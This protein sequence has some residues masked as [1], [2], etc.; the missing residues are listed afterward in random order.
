MWIEREDEPQ[1][2]GDIV[3]RGK[4]DPSVFDVVEG[5]GDSPWVLACDHGGRAIPQCLGD[6]GVPALEL[7]R[8]IA[9]DIGAAAV[10][11]LLADRLGAWAIVGN[12]SRLLIDLNRPLSSPQSI[13]L[14][15]EATDIPGNAGIP[16]AQAEARRREFFEP[17]HLRIAQE[18]DRRRDAGIATLLVAMHSFTPVYLGVVRPWHAGVLY[19]REQRLARLLLETMP[20]EIGLVVGDNQPY[21]VSDA[22]D[23]TVVTHG[24]NRGLV[25]VELEIRQ[26]LVAFQEGRQAWASRLARLLGNAR[27]RL[28]Y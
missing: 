6:L 24:E 1:G 20:A 5:R 12:Y 10:T 21:A 15:S 18:L 13:I 17:Y 19:N 14:H 3:L 7:E 27:E 4:G 16:K 2:D 8:H 26:D 28:G 25:H 22:T 11:R 23:Y 9:W